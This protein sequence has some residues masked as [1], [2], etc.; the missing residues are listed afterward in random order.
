MVYNDPSLDSDPELILTSR[1]I[2]HN[3]IFY[4][5]NDSENINPNI[6]R[7]NK[8]KINKNIIKTIKNNDF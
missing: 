1:K 4:R 6:I 2:Q 5:K 3:I 8:I 7:D